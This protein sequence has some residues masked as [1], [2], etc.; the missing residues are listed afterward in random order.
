M[1]SASIDRPARG[2]YSAETIEARRKIAELLRTSRQA[3]AL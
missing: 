1:K 3:D 2:R